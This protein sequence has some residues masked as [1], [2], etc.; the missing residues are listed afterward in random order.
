MT[1]I[2]ILQQINEKLE[3]LPQINERLGN[4]DFYIGLIVG[5]II[6]LIFWNI[7]KEVK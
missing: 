6:G 1:E 4:L 7:V 5:A 3:I 2:E